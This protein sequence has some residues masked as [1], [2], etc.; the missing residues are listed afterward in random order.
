[1]MKLLSR[2]IHVTRETSSEWEPNSWCLLLEQL[3]LRSPMEELCRTPCGL[4]LFWANY[5]ISS[6]LLHFP[7]LNRY[8]PRICLNVS[9][10]RM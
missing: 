5:T 7:G 4:S 6:I 10:S 2:E 9:N 3:F 8:K 1:M